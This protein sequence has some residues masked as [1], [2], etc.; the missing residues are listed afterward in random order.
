MTGAAANMRGR[1]CRVAPLARHRQLERVDVVRLEV[2][3]EP[4]L[5][6][7][8]V[9]AGDAARLANERV[10]AVRADDPACADRAELLAQG[11][12]A[13]LAH[14]TH[15]QQRAFRLDAQRLRNPP[16]LDRHGG[17]LACAARERLLQRRLEEHVV[18]LP[19]GCRGHG[20]FERHQRLPIG[21]VPVV[22]ADGQ[23]LVG[24]LVR[25]PEALEQPHDLV[26]EVHSARHAVDLGEALD[27]E[28][29]VSGTAQ[30]RRERLPDWAEPDDRDVDVDV[31][32]SGAHAFVRPERLRRSAWQGSGR[33]R[34]RAR[35]AGSR[36]RPCCAT[37]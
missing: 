19:A 3:H 33:A 36:P 35:P 8:E 13:L 5:L 25:D 1:A 11:Q 7:P 6:E 12:I 9:S 27:R 15:G 26:V 29:G 34:R 18:G 21:A 10:G 4:A 23:Q 16:A 24:E 30:Q 14:T 32:G 2:N 20:C 22:V 17:L 28:H 31:V 37:R